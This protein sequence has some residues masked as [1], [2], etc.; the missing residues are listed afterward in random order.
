MPADIGN[1]VYFCPMPCESHQEKAILVL[2][3]PNKKI[4][5][6]L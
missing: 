1:S 4:I 6:K 5:V 3:S 2:W